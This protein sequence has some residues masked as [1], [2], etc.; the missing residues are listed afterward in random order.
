MS[1]FTLDLPTRKVRAE[2]A[3]KRLHVLD[4]ITDNKAPDMLSDAGLPIDLHSDTLGTIGRGNH[5]CELQIIRELN[6]PDAASEGGTFLLVHSGSW[7][8]GTSVFAPVHNHPQDGIDPASGIADE[9]L[10]GYAQAVRWTTLNR[11]LIARR[12]ARACGL[13]IV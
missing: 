2:K 13:I 4:E 3:A 8:L 5:F 11:E 7:S 1:L 10:S 9:Y 6:D 12:A